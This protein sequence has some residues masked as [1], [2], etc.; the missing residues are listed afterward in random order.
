MTQ[1]P[2]I[3]CP[4]CDTVVDPGLPACPGCGLCLGCGARRAKKIERC[5]ACDVPYCDCCG[6][7]PQCLKQRYADLPTCESCGHPTDPGEIERLVQRHAVVG[8]EAAKRS[9][10]GCLGVFG[11]AAMLCVSGIGLLAL[12]IWLER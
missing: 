2:F 7:C 6:R 5:P 3:R 10:V 9:G 4:G 8:A 11:I 1:W 12:L